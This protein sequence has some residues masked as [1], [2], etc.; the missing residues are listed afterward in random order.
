MREAIWYKDLAG[1]FR[2]HNYGRVIPLANM[3]YE[4]QLN[5]VFRLVVYYGVAVS[6]LK[7]DPSYLLLPVAAGVITYGLHRGAENRGPGGGGGPGSGGPGSGGGPGGGDC[8]PPTPDNPFMNL[9]HTEDLTR[10]AA[11]DPFDPRIED[12]IEEYFND[13]I[14]KDV[15][16]IWSSK[17]RSRQFITNPSTTAPNDRHALQEWLYGDMRAGGRKTREPSNS[18]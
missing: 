3:T 4:E 2:G 16:D 1:A 14:Y 10:P 11:C 5:A 17:T 18:A 9:I 15:D 8:Y 13:G 7:L 6:V 12:K